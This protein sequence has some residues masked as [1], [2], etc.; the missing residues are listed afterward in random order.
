MIETFREIAY[1]F[2]KSGKCSVCGKRRKRRTKIW[3]TYNPFNKRADGQVK[4][5]R[6][7]ADEIIAK[8]RAWEREPLVCAGCEASEVQP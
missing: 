4:T 1:Y 7:I 6:E 3:Q 5:E 2:E 8:G